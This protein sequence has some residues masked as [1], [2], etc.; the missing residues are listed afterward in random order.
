[1]DCSCNVPGAERASRDRIAQPN[2]FDLPADKWEPVDVASRGSVIIETA[3]AATVQAVSDRPMGNQHTTGETYDALDISTPTQFRY[4]LYL[5]AKGRWYV[6]TNVAATKAVYRDGWDAFA[7]IREGIRVTGAVQST[8]TAP[9]GLTMSA[10]TFYTAA[11]A[12]GVALAANPLRRFLSLENTDAANPAFVAF[13]AAA[14]AGSGIPLQAKAFKSWNEPGEAVPKG[15]VRII[16]PAGA[17]IAI[18]EGT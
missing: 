13:D 4:V 10:P 7:S 11:A 2:K 14:V 18:Q 5:H 9:T 6:R 12:S 16:S 17:N 3:S 8:V 15:E 1:M